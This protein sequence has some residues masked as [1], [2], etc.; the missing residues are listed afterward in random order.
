MAFTSLS[1]T[2]L[3][4]NQNSVTINIPSGYRDLMLKFSIKGDRASEDYLL[5][6]VNSVTSSSYAWVLNQADGS[7]VSTS[8]SGVFP[9]TQDTSIRL[10][11]IPPSGLTNSAT[12]GVLYLYNYLDST[13]NK[14]VEWSGGYEENV[15]SGTAK[16]FFGGGYFNSTSNVT[17][18]KLYPGYG[19]NL[20]TGST[21]ALYGWTN[22]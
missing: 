13:Y 9:T 21:F 15:S 1:W 17:S 14:T 11:L 6:Q 4:S 3:T 20:T 19:T 10:G 12:I 8:T 22:A 18:I 16:T 2:K 5:M 7:A